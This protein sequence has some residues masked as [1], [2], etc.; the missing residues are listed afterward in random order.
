MKSLIWSQPLEISEGDQMQ[1][2]I[3]SMKFFNF[4]K[5]SLEKN[6][7]VVRQFV[8][9]D[10]IMTVGTGTLNTYLKIN[11]PVTG[12]S[13]QRPQFTNINNGIGIFSSRFTYSI[14]R[15]LTECTRSYL[16]EEL[17]RNFYSNPSLSSINNPCY[18]SP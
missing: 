11:A 5:Q 16:I 8:D 13:Q 10:F 1:S 9:V 7:A 14:K 12:I 2:Q 6:D 3:E 15:S 17:D 18:A 4:L